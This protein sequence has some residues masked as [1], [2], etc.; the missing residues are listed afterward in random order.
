MEQVSWQE[1]DNQGRLVLTASEDG[2]N[3]TILARHYTV[4]E[5]NRRLQFPYWDTSTINRCCRLRCSR[6][7]IAAR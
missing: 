2:T 5:L 7:T 3:G 1:F 4:Y 6:L